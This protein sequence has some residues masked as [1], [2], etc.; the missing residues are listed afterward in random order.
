M[1]ESRFI[2]FHAASDTNPPQAAVPTFAV[3]VARGPAGVVL[4]FN[5]YRQVW[6]LP[7][8]LIDPGESPHDSA[9]RE[10]AEEA[11]CTVHSLD[12]L[13]MVEVADAGHR[14]GAVF[15]CA[16]THVPAR[17]SNDEIEGIA[18]WTPQ[19]SPQPLGRTD[20]ALLAKLF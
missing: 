13:G 1:A 3:V 15:G 4:V 5:R 8:G 20:Q 9:R 7:G 17:M 11:G 10:L 6:E 19:A 18:A 14:W 16:V 2:A 12:W